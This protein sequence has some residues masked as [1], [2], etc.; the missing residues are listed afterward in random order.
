MLFNFS[1]ETDKKGYYNVEK[2]KMTN[3]S[4]KDNEGQL[5]SILRGGNDESTMGPYLIFSKNNISNC[6]T[7]NEEALLY[8]F[9]TQRSEIENNVFTD[10]N[11][12]K[13]LIHYEDLVRAVHVFRNNKLTR[14]G[15]VD[16]NRFVLN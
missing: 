10:C 8:I 13:K 14:S 3:N 7:R 6:V 12:A 4:F 5:L 2:L 1:N 11:P 9:G 16:K 15:N